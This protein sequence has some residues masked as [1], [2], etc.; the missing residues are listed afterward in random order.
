MNKELV[1]RRSISYSHFRRNPGFIK[2]YWTDIDCIELR[3]K[4]GTVEPVMVKEIKIGLHSWPT[5]FQHKVLRMLATHL[6]VPYMLVQL[7][8]IDPN[9]DDEEN[10]KKIRILDGMQLEVEG[11]RGNIKVLKYP[12]N[13]LEK[14]REEYMS[15]VNNL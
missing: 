15:W 8:V 1:H 4:N 3:R 7:D 12:T 2:T 11:E 14:T 13:I 5:A 6:H 9:R 10:I